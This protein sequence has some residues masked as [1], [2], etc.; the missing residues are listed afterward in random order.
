[1]KKIKLIPIVTAGIIILSSA[2][3][4][5]FAPCFNPN[6]TA[7]SEDGSYYEPFCFV[8]TAKGAITVKIGEIAT[9]QTIGYKI[10]DTPIKF[11]IEDENIAK[12][13]EVN[14]ESANIMGI[15]A[16]K[17]VLKAETPDG[18]EDTI[19][20][21]VPEKTNG[22]YFNSSGYIT[23]DT[24]TTAAAGLKGQVGE[25]SITFTVDDENIAKITRIEGA[26]ISVKGISPG[27]TIIHA[28]TSEGETAEL[29]VIVEPDI[30]TVA[31]ETTPS[32]NYTTTV[33]LCGDIYTSYI[34]GDVNSD[35]KVS[36]SD[37]VKI[38]QNISNKEKYPLSEQE[39]IN[40]DC[41]NK[42]DGITGLDAAA[43]QKF[44]AGIIDKLPEVIS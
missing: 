24:H 1:M 2:N 17:T 37:S 7:Y 29:K 27:E 42:G 22:V 41:C 15:S 18:A 36:I 14:G 43:I 8:K 20:I 39:I 10:G 38:L 30:T 33:D 5:N 25:S 32:E 28:E 31:I 4:N 21:I 13:I 44:D 12:V 23:I 34:C 16:G 3:Y 9:A 11:T 35:F 19:T 26:K 40:A 6:I